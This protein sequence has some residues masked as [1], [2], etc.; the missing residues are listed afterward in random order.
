MTEPLSDR[1]LIERSLGEPECFAALFDRHSAEIFR[2][3]ARRLGPDVA[4][5]ATA[6]TFLTAFRKRDRF[7]GERD[8]ARPWL[9]GIATRTIGEHRRAEAR[10]RR[11]LGRLDTTT[12]TEPF[13]ELAAGRVSAQRLGGQ[14]AGMLGRLSAGERDLLLLIAW[15]T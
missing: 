7:S 4:E 11:A 9:Y 1:V 10:R 12:A 6:E 3:L 13:E 5:D 15:R 2:Y 14:L 8:D